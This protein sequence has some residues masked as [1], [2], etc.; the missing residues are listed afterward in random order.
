[1]NIEESESWTCSNYDHR[2]IEHRYMKVSYANM[3]MWSVETCKQVETCMMS[4][5]SNRWM[6]GHL[7]WTDLK[8]QWTSDLKWAVQW[9]KHSSNRRI[10]L[11][12]RLLMNWAWEDVNG[13][14]RSL[15]IWEDREM[16]GM[17]HSPVFSHAC[18]YHDTVVWSDT[19]ALLKGI[20]FAVPVLLIYLQL[21]V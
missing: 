19:K 21:T 16:T 14:K 20:K 2:H 1:M 13:T 15:K 11:S 3:K 4:L 18:F 6:L 7:V 8:T 10:G 17:G 5:V 12:Q 9:S